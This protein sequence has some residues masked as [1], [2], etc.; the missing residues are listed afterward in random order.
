MDDR[1]KFERDYVLT[2]QGT[3]VMSAE[4]LAEMWDEEKQQYTKPGV[5]LMYFG[6]MIRTTAD[7]A[8]E[9]AVTKRVLGEAFQPLPTIKRKQSIN[10]WGTTITAPPGYVFGYTLA[11]NCVWPVGLS[12]GGIDYSTHEGSGAEYIDVAMFQMDPNVTAFQIRAAE[13]EFNKIQDAFHIK[14]RFSASEEIEGRTVQHE[15]LR[16]TLTHEEFEGAQNA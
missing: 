3:D 1:K 8:R 6:Y 15:L 2:A 7:K 14:T 10:A 13:R 5:N 4:M 11:S 9:D 12:V 16:L